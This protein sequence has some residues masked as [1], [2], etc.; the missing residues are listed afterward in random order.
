MSFIN[1]N[2]KT[3][4]FNP[5]TI[6]FKLIWLLTNLPLLFHLIYINY[7]NTLNKLN[8]I[9]SLYYKPQL[10]NF[11]FDNLTF[12]VVK[13]LLKTKKFFQTTQLVLSF[14]FWV[15]KHLLLLN[16]KIISPLKQLQLTKK[17]YLNQYHSPLVLT[18]ISLLNKVYRKFLFNTLLFVTYWWPNFNKTKLLT[19]QFLIPTSNLKLFIYY[20]N[21]FFKIFNI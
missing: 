9:K 6:K 19:T 12:V 10:N 7:S 3:T 15:T 1:Q 17:L 20:N 4:T 14:K 11:F 13:K 18:N 16:T 21:Y 5:L 2:F 8:F